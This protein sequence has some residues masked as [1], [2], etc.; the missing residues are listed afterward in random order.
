[1]KLSHAG[2]FKIQ[3]CLRQLAALQAAPLARGMM[4]VRGNLK[5]HLLKEGKNQKTGQEQKLKSDKKYW[6]P[7][8]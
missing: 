6:V 5:N 4:G 1:M 7:K 3:T 8:S 2:L